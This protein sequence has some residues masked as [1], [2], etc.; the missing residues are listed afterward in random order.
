[1]GL[2]GKLWHI[3]WLK[4]SKSIS[5]PSI[6]NL[7]FSKWL[8]QLSYILFCCGSYAPYNVNLFIAFLLK[9][10]HFYNY[11]ILVSHVDFTQ[12][13]TRLL[14]PKEKKEKKLQ[15]CQDA[16]FFFFLSKQKCAMFVRVQMW[17]L[18]KVYYFA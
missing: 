5:Y 7:W 4:Q 2:S 11:N 1:M 17:K 12:Q 6:I 15:S 13:N 8:K 9:Y 14:R 3:K 16:I 18:L 10:D